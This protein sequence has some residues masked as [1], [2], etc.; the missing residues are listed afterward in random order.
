MDYTEV[1][2][3]PKGDDAVRN[4]GAIWNGIADALD[5]ALMQRENLLLSNN[6]F[7]KS[8]DD[9]VYHNLGV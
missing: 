5:L 9:M 4:W 3:F 6:V 1:Y 7:L 2:D 8:G